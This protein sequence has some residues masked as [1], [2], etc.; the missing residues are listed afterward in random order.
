MTG[1]VSKV[2][3]SS[4]TFKSEEETDNKQCHESALPT[5][6]NTVKVPPGDKRLSEDQACAEKNCEVVSSQQINA[7]VHNVKKATPKSIQSEEAVSTDDFERRKEEI[8]KEVEEDKIIKEAH[9]EQLRQEL[10]L[11]NSAYSDKEKLA[12]RTQ[13]VIQEGKVNVV[14][15]RPKEAV[16]WRQEHIL[17]TRTEEEKRQRDFQRQQLLAQQRKQ[18][19]VAKAQEIL[20][21]KKQCDFSVGTRSS[22]FPKKVMEPSLTYTDQ[23]RILNTHGNVH[24]Q[25]IVLGRDSRT[26]ETGKEHSMSQTPLFA[27][28]KYNETAIEIS[29]EQDAI[30]K[31]D[32]QDSKL[33]GLREKCHDL[34]TRLEAKTQKCNE[35]ENLLISNEQTHNDCIKALQNELARSEKARLAIENKYTT[36]H[37]RRF[38]NEK[39]LRQRSKTSKRGKGKVISTQGFQNI[40][41]ISRTSQAREMANPTVGAKSPHDLIRSESSATSNQEKQVIRSISEFFGIM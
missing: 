3:Q 15:K 36:M 41:I 18:R 33:T 9:R 38:N 13:E 35:L 8:R 5:T 29:M 25:S 27:N 34:E 6:S 14:N 37:A 39:D 4:N 28:G 30:R 40:G 31:R 2:D 19:E 22:V 21:K 26:N 16:T 1:Q 23:N 32:E 12:S 11:E 10:V 24:H 20:R 17:P 7:Q